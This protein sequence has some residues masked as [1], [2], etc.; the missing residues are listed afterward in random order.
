MLLCHQL[1]L[2]T[3]IFVCLLF[4]IVNINLILGNTQSKIISTQDQVTTY[5]NQTA[6]LSCIIKK[7]QS[8]TC[9]MVSYSS[10]K[11]NS[12]INVSPICRLA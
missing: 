4:F 9:Y 1:I 3:R 5:V 8:T 6:K 10:H 2:L 11:R 7:S 12:K